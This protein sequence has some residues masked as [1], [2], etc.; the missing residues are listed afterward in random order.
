[1]KL[2]V[3]VR[4]AKGKAVKN[5]RK[6]WLLPAVVYGKTLEA[7]VLLSCLKND[8]IKV[9]RAVWFSTP[10]ELEGGIKQL[11]L[12]HDMQLDP[13]T[14]EVLSVDFLAVNQNEKVTASVPVVLVWESKVEKLNEWKIQQVKD[15]VEVEAYPKDL[16]HNIEVDISKIESVNDVIFVKDLVISDKVRIVDDAEQPVITV[17]ELSDEEESSGE[18]SAATP[19]AEWTAAA[20]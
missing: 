7:P 5:L 12:V 18:E 13:V 6:E 20:E 19:A 14:D 1:M 10:V 17:V 4:T 16:P 9:Y 15:E 11:V 2:N 3:Q 8:F